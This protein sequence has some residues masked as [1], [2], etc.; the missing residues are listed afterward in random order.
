[1]TASTGL[2]GTGFKSA[3]KQSYET[4]AR[5]T[6]GLSLQIYIQLIF[7]TLDHLDS[8]SINWLG[9]ISLAHTI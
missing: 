9:E 8:R 1:M 4:M 5:V 7:S 6:T 2:L 3:E